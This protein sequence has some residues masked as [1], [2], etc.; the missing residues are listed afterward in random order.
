MVFCMPGSMECSQRRTLDAKYLP[1]LNL[2]LPGIGLVLEDL[3]AG[4]DLEQIRNAIDVVTVPVRN[5]GLVHGGFLF[6]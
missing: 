1:V 5:Q 4:T 6:R 2:C 3:R